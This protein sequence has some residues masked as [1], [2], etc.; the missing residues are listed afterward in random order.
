M[1]VRLSRSCSAPISRATIRIMR[2]DEEL[3]PAPSTLSFLCGD[4]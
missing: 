1:R 4:N 2:T 3:M